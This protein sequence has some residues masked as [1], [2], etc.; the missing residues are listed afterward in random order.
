MVLRFLAR[1]AYLSVFTVSSN[2]RC[3]GEMFA[4]ITVRQLPPSESL[5]NRVILESRYGT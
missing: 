3:E 1:L 2:W 5:S 4:S